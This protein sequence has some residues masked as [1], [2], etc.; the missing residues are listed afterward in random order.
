MTPEA[1]AALHARC[2]VR[3]PPWTAGA[4][5]ALLASPG[6]FLLT[7]PAGDPPAPGFLLGRAVAGEA[8]VLTLAVDPAV[9]RAGAGRTLIAAF[10]VEARQRDARE[11]FLEVA[12]NNDAALGLYAATGWQAA[13]R[14]PGYYGPGID[15]LVLRHALA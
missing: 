5:A 9:R 10:L 11:A 15:A 12:S 1:L 14:R 3:P 6:V 2:F 13:G 8:E 4:F 7:H